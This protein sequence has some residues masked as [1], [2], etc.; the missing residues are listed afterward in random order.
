MIAVNSCPIDCVKKETRLSY[1][2]INGQH[3]HIERILELYVQPGIQLKTMS[4]VPMSHNVEHLSRSSS[5]AFLFPG[6][7]GIE[8][9]SKESPDET[10]GVCNT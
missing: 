3:T 5:R 7:P 9:D 2:R 8:N 1:I 4:V 10:R 6:M